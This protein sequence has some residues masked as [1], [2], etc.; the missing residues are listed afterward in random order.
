MEQPSEITVTI[1]KSTLVIDDLGRW[2]DAAREFKI[3]ISGAQLLEI[4]EDN[5]DIAFDA[6]KF[7]AGDT[8]VGDR[9]FDAFVMHI[10]GFPWSEIESRYKDG[11]YVFVEVEALKKG[12]VG[13]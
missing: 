12:Y 4:I 13:V 2:Y 7:G 11:K 5:D 9:F 8:E 6:A 1:G 3:Q 10:T